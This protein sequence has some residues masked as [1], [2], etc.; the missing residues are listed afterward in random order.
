MKEIGGYFGLDQFI[1]KP[2]HN[3]M[4]ELNTGR[5]A[6]IYVVKSK[7]IKK[8]YLPFF[9]CDSVTKILDKHIVEYEYYHIDKK[10]MPVFNK[11]LKDEEYLYVVNYYGQINDDQI[12]VLKEKYHYIIVDNTQAFFQ[13]PISG[14][15]TIYSCRKFFGV[16]DG[17]YLSTNSILAEELDEDKSSTRMDHILGRFE[18]QASDFYNDFQA[19]D[20]FLG[21][22]PLK[23]MSKLTSNILGAID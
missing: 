10:F 3:N 14:I 7:K 8:V 6:L 20:E 4:I 5:N 18:G 23:R 9:L 13:K 21:L 19:N 17:S 1:S 22:L 12:M 16:P 11:T 15:D 2:Y